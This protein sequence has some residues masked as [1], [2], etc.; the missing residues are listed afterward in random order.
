MSSVNMKSLILFFILLIMGGVASYWLND[1]LDFTRDVLEEGNLALLTILAVNLI[2][3]LHAVSMKDTSEHE[4]FNFRS[5][6]WILVAFFECGTFTALLST[7]FAFFE[8]VI[9]QQ[10]F[11]DKIYFTPL[12]DVNHY[13]LLAVAG[14]LFWFPLFQVYIKGKDLFIKREP[15]TA[16]SNDASSADET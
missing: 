6:V 14:L 13:V 16:A 10:F 15:T 4:L 12:F 9:I 2:I 8:G 7:S 3:I 11:G 5:G 1:I